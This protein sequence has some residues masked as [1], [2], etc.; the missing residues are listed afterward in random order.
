MV[1]GA[2]KLWNSLDLFALKCRLYM[3]TDLNVTARYRVR[4]LHSFEDCLI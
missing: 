2:L 4:S 1:G 3:R